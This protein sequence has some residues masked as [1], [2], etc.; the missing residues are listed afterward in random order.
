MTAFQALHLPNG[1]TITN[2]IAKAA[3][4]ENLAD[5]NQGPSA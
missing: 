5:A 1:T 2:R 3:M 4:E